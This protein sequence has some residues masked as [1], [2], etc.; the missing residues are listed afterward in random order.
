MRWRGRDVG[1]GRVGYGVGGWYL[2]RRCKRTEKDD[3]RGYGC[4]CEKMKTPCAVVV[5]K[6]VKLQIGVLIPWV[7]FDSNTMRI[8]FMLLKDGKR[9]EM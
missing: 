4:R 3:K 9:G 6:S 8:V 1:G 2:G 7:R 5:R